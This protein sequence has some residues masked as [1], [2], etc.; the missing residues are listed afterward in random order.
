MKKKVLVI[1]GPTATGKSALA[2]SL[3]LS[4]NGE[5]ISADSRQVYKGLDIGSGKITKEE[6]MGIQHHLID[7]VDPKKRFTVVDFQ[8]VAREK[9]SEIF[10][11]GNIPIICGGTGFY[12]QSLVDNVIFPEV[13]PD[14]RLREKL[15]RKTAPVL[16]KMLTKLD[17]KKAKSIDKNNKRRIIRSIEIAKTLGKV[18]KMKNGKVDNLK[19]IEIGIDLPDDILKKRIEK[20]LLDRLN[21]GMVDEVRNLYRKGLSWKKLDSFGL[22]YRFVSLF[23]QNKISHEQMVESLKKEI[24]QFVRRQRTWFRRNKRIKWFVPTDIEEIDKYISKKY[25]QVD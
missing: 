11:R 17:P 4:F 5:I 16:L 1:L 6:M 19:F 7:I 23:L 10:S 13:Q 2:V 15:N 3:A 24:W 25:D 9:I 20:R 18:P 8:K 12:I 14:K 22:E 21:R